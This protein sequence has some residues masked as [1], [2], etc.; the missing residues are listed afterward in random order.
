MVQGVNACANMKY[1]AEIT[2]LDKDIKE[3]KFISDEEKV[4]LLNEL[5]GDNIIGLEAHNR[6]QLIYKNRAE[7]AKGHGDTATK[8]QLM[9]WVI[10]A[11]CPF[12]GRFFENTIG[13][14]IAGG[15]IFYAAFV[16]VSKLYEKGIDCEF[17]NAHLVFLE[18]QIHSVNKRCQNSTTR[19]ATSSLSG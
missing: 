13:G 14:L 12:A 4:V 19:S 7:D 17:I 2:Q 6:L 3:N 1:V 8:I 5:Y 16:L 11:V 10:S 15:T 9:S 18:E